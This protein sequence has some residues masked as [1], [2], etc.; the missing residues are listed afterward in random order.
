MV[1][2]AMGPPWPLTL[3]MTIPIAMLMGVYC[4]LAAGVRPEASVLG[5]PSSSSRWW[6]AS[7]WR[8]RCSGPAVHAVGTGPAVAVIVYGFAASALPV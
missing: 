6:P 2:N 3:A 4:A 7:G 1:V 8:A 5:S